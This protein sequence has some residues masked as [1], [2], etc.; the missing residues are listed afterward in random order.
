MQSI[1]CRDNCRK[2]TLIVIM[3]R[4]EKC[5]A[6]PKNTLN[7]ASCV[8]YSFIREDS[9]DL[10]F[11]NCHDVSPDM[12]HSSQRNVSSC[13]YRLKEVSLKLTTIQASTVV[14]G[15]QVFVFKYLT[16]S[17]LWRTLWLIRIALAVQY[18]WDCGLTV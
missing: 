3:L 12:I 4:Q 10:Q 13:E 17:S 9:R 7:S 18:C 11:G 5:C 8:E 1:I 2:L 16:S 14:Y 15:H 6:T